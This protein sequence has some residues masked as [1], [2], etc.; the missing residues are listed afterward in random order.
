MNWLND[1]LRTNAKYVDHGKTSKFTTFANSQ[2]SKKKEES[3]H[4]G[5]KSWLPAGERPW[6]FATTV[7]R[8]SIKDNRR[9][10]GKRNEQTESCMHRKMHVQFGGGRATRSCMTSCE[11]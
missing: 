3:D 5:S 7:T 2:T 11:G 1:S 9:D 4:S 6:L 8:P 10:R